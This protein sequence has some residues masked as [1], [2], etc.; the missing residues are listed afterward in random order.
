MAAERPLR[1]EVELDGSGTTI[2]R[3][4]PGPPGAPTALLLHGWGATARMNWGPCFEPLSRS[5]RVLAID[6][7]GHGRGLPTRRFDL[8]ECADDAMAI[9]RARGCDS[10]IA[11]GWSMGGPIASL[12]WRRHGLRVA[13]LVLCAT[14]RH[15]VPRTVARAAVPAMRSLAIVAP[16]MSVA[17]LVGRSVARTRDSNLRARY[18]REYSR[19]DPRALAGAFDA[20][21]RFS[22]HDW[23]GD[24]DVPTA[25]IVTKRDGLVPPSRQR[26]L[27]ASIRDAEVFEVDGDHSVCTSAPERFVPTLVEACRSVAERGAAE[28]GP[29]RTP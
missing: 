24:I 19:H 12:A 17:G 29:S 21:S 7:R 15:F 18:R 27:A 16:S 20:L 22:S 14:G 25:C 6:H 4:I 1:M 9:A 11:V 5:F 2:V 28:R 23:V 8:A 13:G 3:E 10:V 26:R